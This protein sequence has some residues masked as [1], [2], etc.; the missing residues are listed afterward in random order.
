MNYEE[1][2]FYFANFYYQSRDTSNDPECCCRDV[3]KSS[4]GEDPNPSNC[5]L[6]FV[7]SEVGV[8]DNWN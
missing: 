3:G 5:L 4:A 6:K 7:N 2:L 1:K 8:T